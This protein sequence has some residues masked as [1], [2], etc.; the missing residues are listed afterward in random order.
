MRS[1]L[2]FDK[3]RLIESS[4]EEQD[5]YVLYMAEDIQTK[6]KY[7][8]YLI[9]R[10]SLLY[11][12]FSNNLHRILEI[13][14]SHK[15]PLI[16]NVKDIITKDD[17]LLIVFEMKNKGLLSLFQNGETIL[18]SQVQRLFYIIAQII[19]YFHTRKIAI[20]DIQPG[21]FYLTNSGLLKLSS[22]QYS[23]IFSS[24]EKTTQ[25]PGSINYAAPEVFKGPYN[26]FAADIW[27]LG[28]TLYALLDGDAPIKGDTVDEVKE[29]LVN[30]KTFKIPEYFGEK[31]A[32]LLRKMLVVDPLKRATITDV[33][34]H[35]FLQDIVL[36]SIITLKFTPQRVMERIKQFTS[37]KNIKM[38]IINDY[39]FKLKF[40]SGNIFY[41]IGYLSDIDNQTELKL[42]GL[43]VEKKEDFDDLIDAFKY[44]C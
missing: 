20:L 2:Q 44:L 37:L 36:Q 10:R 32:D 15:Y 11:S 38:T 18:E 40:L 22:F 25:I 14:A 33:I 26:P 17:I 28:M 21:S 29:Q 41:A 12:S 27:A 42:V 30:M 3:Y 16:Q 24:N 9:H 34:N 43:I 31:P 13:Q 6:Q 8:A 35:P 23:G 19:D 7:T 4:A 1:S 5:F 39:L